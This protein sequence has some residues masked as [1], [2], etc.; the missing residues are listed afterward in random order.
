MG[1]DTRGCA[2]HEG[3]HVKRILTSGLVLLAGLTWA[4][5]ASA[6]LKLGLAAPITGPSAST[7]TQMK[8]GVEQAIADINAQGGILGEKLSLSIGDDVSDPK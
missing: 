2:L 7:G 3:G 8:N 6:E 1:A 4:G 5:A